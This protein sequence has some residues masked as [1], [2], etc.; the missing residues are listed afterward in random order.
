MSSLP[1]HE[2]S[3]RQ[4]LVLSSFL[5]ALNA[6]DAVLDRALW[7]GLVGQILVGVAWGA[8]GARWLDADVQAAVAQL[9]YLGLV[10]V[11]FEGGAATAPAPPVGNR[12]KS[13]NATGQSWSRHCSRSNSSAVDL[14]LAAAVALTGIAG[15]T[16]LSF[17]ALGPLAGATSPVQ[18]FAA[19]AALCSTSLGTTFAVLAATGLARSRLG[20]L[21]GA[22]ATMDDVVGLVAAQVVARLGGTGQA[23]VDVDVVG[24]IVRPVLVSVAFAVVVPVVARFGV[25]LLVGWVAERRTRG[26][27]KVKGRTGE[28]AEE[29]G[30]GFL[31]LTHV[32]FIAQTALLVAL[33][34]AASYAGASV[35]LAAY[36]AGIVVS[37]WQ[38]LQENH[39]KTTT[40]DRE[41]EP[42]EGVNT[43]DQGL[44]DNSD[45]DPQMADRPEERQLQRPA[46]PVPDVYEIFYAQVVRRTLKPFFFA[47]IGFSIPVSAM[48]TGDVVWRGVVYGILMALGKMLCGLWLARLPISV[49][50]T[51]R[52][53][54]SS[55]CRAVSSAIRRLRAYMTPQRSEP[56]ELRRQ[57]RPAVNAGDMSPA[58]GDVRRTTPEQ[59]QQPTLASNDSN[60]SSS[61]PHP[62]VV[63]AKPLSLY[64]AA[65]VSSAMVARGEIGFLI[66]A[67][68]ES[69][70]VFGR[71][72][73][74][75]S[76]ENETSELFLIVTW[77][78][79]L[80]TIAGPVLVGLLVRR[81]KKLEGRATRRGAAD[82]GSAK[83][84]LGAWGVRGRG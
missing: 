74:A 70:G 57:P 11:V 54:V 43:T 29:E 24:A 68:A 20:R 45:I 7:C 5:L 1:Y 78:I 44:E 18:R 21:L 71:P 23:D 12:T 76:N 27:G 42:S 34:V 28:E 63:P 48:F 40:E 49:S 79:V 17:A 39:A 50:A 47:S 19:A 53:L 60:D 66:S 62:S 33:V 73:N 67:V 26:K 81:V 16:A 4:I 14:A 15:P 65:I 6:A 55:R 58:D 83:N 32:S 10:L 72:S 37:W 30:E 41:G 64:P 2:P 25:P 22:A 80:C 38:D 13:T 52:S 61:H 35:L 84:V 31:G 51:L 8:P 3:I 36:L 46:H 56:V 77:A 59:Q 75:D 69:H 9:G 82:G